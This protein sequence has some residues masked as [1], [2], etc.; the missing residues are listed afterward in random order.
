MNHEEKSIYNGMLV[1]I[2]FMCLPSILLTWLFYETI[3]FYE[4]QFGYELNWNS[5]KLL[6]TGMGIIIHL[7]FLLDGAFKKDFA[8]VTNRIKDFFSYLSVSP[9]GVLKLYWDDVRENG[10]TF[11]IYFSVIIVNILFFGNSLLKVLRIVLEHYL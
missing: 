1:K 9:K 11:W 10:M 7:L 6:G 3:N 8:I 5:A 2:L 4:P